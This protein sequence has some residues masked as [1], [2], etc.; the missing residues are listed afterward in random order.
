MIWM[1]L[2][3]ACADKGTDTATD[4]TDTG[5]TEGT[6][7]LTFALDPDY[8]ALMDEDP[9]GNFYGALWRDEDVTGAGP[10]EG[11]EDLGSIE[12]DN[13]NLLP[14]GGPTGVLFTTGPLSGTI[15]VLGFLD[16]DA[17]N[18]ADLSPDDGDPV[19]LPGDNEFE[20]VP[21]AETTVQVYFGLLKP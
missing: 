15:V 18:A 14:D 2:A 19:T 21:G 9:V 11:A 20:V 10:D 13:M 12:V 8:M 7:A 1:L 16:S 6:L 4:D 3:L 5:S 17:N